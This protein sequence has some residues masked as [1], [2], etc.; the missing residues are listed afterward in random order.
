MGPPGSAGRGAL[1]IDLEHIERLGRGHEKMIALGP[2]E[3]DIGGPFRQPDAADRL[4]VRIPHGHAGVPQNTIGTG[5]D[6]AGPVH[7][8]AVG[9]A[10]D[11][12]DH[13]VGEF[14]QV[15]YLAVHDIPGMNAAADDIDALIVRRK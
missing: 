2:A 6:I 8:Y 13:A 10:V 11:A 4:A 14:A 9:M 7:P 5:P 15:R 12:V 1:N 3:T